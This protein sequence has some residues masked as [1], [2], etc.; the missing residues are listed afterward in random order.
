[1]GDTG[2]ASDLLCVRHNSRAQHSPSEHGDQSVGAPPSTRI[3]GHCQSISQAVQPPHISG[4]PRTFTADGFAGCYP[5]GGVQLPAEGSQL[6]LT[7][8]FSTGFRSAQAKET[9]SSKVGVGPGA[10]AADLG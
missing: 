5:A 6:P 4:R 7:G 9:A 10:S 2:I 3:R 8:P 1:V